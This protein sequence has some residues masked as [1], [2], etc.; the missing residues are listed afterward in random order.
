MKRNMRLFTCLVLILSMVLCTVSVF[1]AENKA[2]ITSIKELDGKELG[3]QTAVSYEDAIKDEIPKA[4][5]NYFQMPNDMI[6]ALESNKITAYLIEEVGFAAQ[7]FEHP[8]L[9][10]LEEAAG[11]IDF[12]ISVGNNDRQTLLLSQINQFVKDAHNDGTVDQMYDYWITNWNPDT[13]RIEY[14]PQNA[15][16]NG[17]VNIAI[18]GAYEPFSFMSN[19]ELSGFDVEFMIR[20]CDKYG[21]E[22]VFFEV[23]FDSISAG[24]E[25]GKYDYG[26]NIVLTDERSEGAKLSEVYYSCDIVFVLEAELEESMGFFE[27]L[28]YS[29]NKTFIKENRWKM[30]AEGTG[31]TVMITLLSTLFGTLLG[32]A[33]FMGCRTGNKLVNTATDFFAWL[34]HGMPTVVLLMILFYIVFGSSTLSGVGIS[35]IGFSMIFGCAMLDM[36]RVGFGAI[37]KGQSEA[38]TA[39]GYSDSQAF[40]KILLPQAAQHFL[41]IY[42]NELVTLIKESSIVGYIAV[43]DLTKISDLVRSRTYE[44]FFPLIATA[45]IYIVIESLMILAVKRV[46]L[47]I[48]PKLRSREKILEGIVTED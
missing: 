38:S 3:V 44:A 9:V 11:S 27:K 25:Q 21:Y 15:P 40:F 18:E 46:Q 34:I 37:S 2:G 22:P 23:P 12:V 31:V 6:L 1:A 14:E 39:L 32:F 8:E 43:L 28:G 5:W 29:F 24:V 20:F 17:T 33:L 26:M 13:C 35:V 45:I 47:N 42:R 16:E 36:L 30:F 41:P 10:R 48:N 19:G 4:H 7:V